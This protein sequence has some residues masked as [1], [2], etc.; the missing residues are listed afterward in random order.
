MSSTGFLSAAWRSRH[1]CIM[2]GTL[3]CLALDHGRAL[4][5]TKEPGGPPSTPASPPGGGGVPGPR[6]N[7]GGGS[8][9]NFGGFSGFQNV[10]SGFGGF[11]SMQPQR[12]SFPI[13]ANA[14][15]RDLL[16]SPPDA[17]KTYPAWVLTDLKYAPEVFFQTPSAPKAP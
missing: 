16:P 10:G 1:M 13:S 12:F 7:N 11:S 15:L 6:V 5:Q 8:F 9:G 17:G 4:G 2:L 3:A 14:H